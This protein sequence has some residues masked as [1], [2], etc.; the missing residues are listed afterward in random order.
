MSKSK[1]LSRSQM[2]VV[3]KMISGN[4]ETKLRTVTYNETAIEGASGTPLNSQLTAISQGDDQTDRTGNLI[5]ATGI[6]ARFA[7][8]GADSTNKIRMMFYIPKDS[9]DSLDGSD[10]HSAIDLDKYTIL[11]DRVLLTSQ[12]GNDNIGVTF[13]KSFTRR[14]KAKGISVRYSGTTS[15]DVAQNGIKFYCVSDSDAVS[16]PTITGHYRFYFKD[17]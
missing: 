1:G 10:I 11:F 8:T 17:G 15:N 6:Y 5:F 9:D 14:G 13:K 4:Q 7:V 16:H 3:Q 12:N 2:R